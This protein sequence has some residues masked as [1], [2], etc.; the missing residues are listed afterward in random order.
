MVKVHIGWY[1][2]HIISVWRII[3]DDR[4]IVGILT[5]EYQS[6]TALFCVVKLKK[7]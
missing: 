4:F 2:T 3:P 6:R 1:P 7:S 5:P